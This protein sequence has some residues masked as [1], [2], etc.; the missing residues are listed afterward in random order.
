LTDREVRGDVTREE[1]D[2]SPPVPAGRPAG[3][4]EEDPY[5]GVDLSSYPDW[6]REA[7]E[8]FREHGM[9]PYRPPRFADDELVPPT[10]ADLEAELGVRIEL[11]S[12]DPGPHPE[13]AVW[14]DGERV[15]RIGRSREAD[16]H[17]A[18]ELDREAFEALVREAVGD[19][20]S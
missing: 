18:Y 5:D 15:E 16:G 10:V 3:Y 11:R 8:R 1:P 13:W 14:I 6:W 17:T 2:P 20:G 7:I 4:D 19:D 12:T 9:R